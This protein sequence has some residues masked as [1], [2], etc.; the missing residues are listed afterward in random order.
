MN[1]ELVR[2]LR[3]LAA[4]L[5]RAAPL[6]RHLPLLAESI[7]SPALAAAVRRAEER[8]RE[9]LPLHAALGEVLPAS[10]IAQI[11]SGL[12]SARLPGLLR[13]LAERY[14][15]ADRLRRATLRV[16]VPVV[17]G[18]ALFAVGMGAAAVASR[19]F[20]P[21]YADMGVALPLPTQLL[22]E[23]QDI[24]PATLA[25]GAFG[26]LMTIAAIVWVLVRHTPLA[27][28]EFLVPIW[29]HVARNRDL[30]AYCASMSALLEANVPLPVAS[31][32]SSRVVR[33]GWLR[34]ALE[35]AAKRAESGL[36]SV[37]SLASERAIP[38]TL[39]W[40]LGPA[41]LRGDV[42]GVFRAF[43]D[44]YSR[45]LEGSTTVAVQMVPT[46]G[47]VVVLTFAV[48][49]FAALFM[50]FLMLLEGIK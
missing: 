7:A 2:L 3:S 6:E 13:A 10:E 18:M 46:I 35:R 1:A 28:L 41:Q 43:A 22:M 32:I 30:A 24:P 44:V 45:Q 20:A 39:I 15:L 40:A 9:G 29:A 17:A 16:L 21:M 5:E 33:N 37:D 26:V 23:L 31:E 19:A 11:E 49:V 42:P 27:R 48:A 12:A 38:R 50:P 8:L 36:D 4:V 14:A 25:T 34:A 47:I